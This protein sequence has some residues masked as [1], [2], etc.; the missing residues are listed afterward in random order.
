[1]FFLS[2][3]FFSPQPNCSYDPGLSVLALCSRTL[4]PGEL[5]IWYTPIHLIRWNAAD[6][7]SH[8]EESPYCVS[9]PR[10]QA[11]RAPL[12]A[13]RGSRDTHAA[14]HRVR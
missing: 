1:M 9:V 10:D 5:P 7:T 3:L 12:R 6:D 14:L 2:F 11:S 13:S 8:S 4:I